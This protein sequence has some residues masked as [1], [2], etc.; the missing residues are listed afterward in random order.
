MY[1][2]G[3]RKKAKATAK[4]EKEA[5]YTKTMSD[6]QR[7]TDRLNTPNTVAKKSADISPLLKKSVLKLPYGKS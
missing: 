3:K 2:D 4:S 1:N 7:M 6:I 5:N